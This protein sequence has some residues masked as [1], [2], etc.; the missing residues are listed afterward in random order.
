MDL[1]NA[2]ILYFQIFKY[3]TNIAYVTRSKK[4]YIK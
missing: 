1:F 3:K 2:N 4:K